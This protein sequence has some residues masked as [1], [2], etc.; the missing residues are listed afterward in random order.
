MFPVFVAVFILTDDFE[1]TITTTPI[2]LMRMFFLVWKLILLYL[3]IS[4]QFLI[5]RSKL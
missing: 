5:V 1:A 2:V 3:L 4:I